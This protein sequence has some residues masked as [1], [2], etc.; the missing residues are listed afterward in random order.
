MIVM[1]RALQPDTVGQLVGMVSADAAIRSEEFCQEV[2]SSGNV[3]L[4]RQQVCYP[5]MQHQHVPDKLGETV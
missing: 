2:M 5:C 3:G 1:A 4:N